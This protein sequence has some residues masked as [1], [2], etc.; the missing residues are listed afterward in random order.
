MELRAR[1]GISSPAARSCQPSA[2]QAAFTS[3]LSNQS[4]PSLS[5]CTNSRY[6]LAI[7][8]TSLVQVAH[9]P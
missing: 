4:P 2:V 1:L 9:D 6:T 5:P 3:Q 8:S 7:A